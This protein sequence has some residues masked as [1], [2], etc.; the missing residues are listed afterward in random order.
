ME[1]KINFTVDDYFN[2]RTI[3]DFLRKKHDVS[4]SL[5]TQLKQS[6]N[7]ILLNGNHAAV[8]E[9]IKVGD[10]VTITLPEDKNEIEPINIPIKILYEDAHIIAYDKPP[11]MPT[12]PVRGHLD[13]T[14]ANAAAYYALSKGENY[15]F[16]AINRLDRDTSGIVLAAKNAYCASILPKST[17]KIYIGICEGEISTPFTIDKPIRLK[18]GHTIQREVGEGGVRAITHGEPIKIS[19]GHTLI[20]FTLETGRTHQIR[21]HMASIGHPLAGDDMYGGSRT[22]F[23]R[24][25]LHCGEISFMHPVNREFVSIGSDFSSSFF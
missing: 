4:A 2:Q 15:S 21:V 23:P 6:Q 12:H 22:F 9:K 3:K 1:T 13:D 14:L 20:R 8:I 18:E 16:R 17:K 11:F 7:G 19:N 5:L 24:Q 10:V 25:A